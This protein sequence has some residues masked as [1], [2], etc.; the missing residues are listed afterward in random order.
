MAAGIADVAAVL[1]GATIDDVAQGGLVNAWAWLFLAAAHAG[2]MTC[3]AVS[4][5]NDEVA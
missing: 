3:N 1:R 4:G 5:S 2:E